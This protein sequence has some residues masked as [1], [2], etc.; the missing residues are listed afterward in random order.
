LDEA[1]TKHQ[2]GRILMHL[3]ARRGFQSNR[4]SL[5]IGELAKEYEDLSDAADSDKTLDDSLT[6]QD[7]ED[8]GK[9]KNEI[10]GLWAEMHAK[11]CR[12][13]GELLADI[14]P[15]ERKRTRHTDRKMYK[16]EFELLWQSQTRFHVDL[17]DDGFKANVFEMIF[18]QRPLKSA[19]GLVAPCSLEPL[20]K[21]AMRGRLDVQEFL[22]RQDL[23]HLQ[24]LDPETREFQP[25]SLEQRELLFQAL[26]QQ[27]SLSWGQA[28]K[29]IGAPFPKTQKFSLEDSKAKLNGNRVVC[30]L[31][32]ALPDRWDIL[33]RSDQDQL[34]EDLLT[35]SAKNDLIK[36]LREH[37]QF[38]RE[39]AYQL[40]IREL[41]SVTP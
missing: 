14:P 16:E 22:L 26:Q 19:K 39:Q 41:R 29:L 37:W 25:I 11:Q 31:R 4:K 7:D 38:T 6:K 18:F 20:R 5:L 35:I 9:I 15:L 3:C 10:V 23:N 32:D 30:L 1:L 34:V 36:R 12:T 24:L 28:K 40:A 21:R 13:L 17:Q 2:F 33:S 8:L 27:A